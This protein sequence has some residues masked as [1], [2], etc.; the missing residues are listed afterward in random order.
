MG[1]EREAY[2]AERATVCGSNKGADVGAKQSMAAGVKGR[3]TAQR[4]CLSM[5]GWVTSDVVGG[6]SKE[7]DQD[8]SRDH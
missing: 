1:R 4:V 5:M 6:R 2:V 8:R 3:G 7:I